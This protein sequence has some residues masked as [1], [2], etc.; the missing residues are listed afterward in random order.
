MLGYISVSPVSQ[1]HARRWIVTFDDRST[2]LIGN[3]HAPQAPRLLLGSHL[4]GRE[5]L[6]PA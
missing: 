2:H 5:M 3:V 6:P 1:G 4:G